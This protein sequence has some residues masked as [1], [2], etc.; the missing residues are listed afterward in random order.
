LHEGVFWQRLQLQSVGP[1]AMMTI[2][3]VGRLTGTEHRRPIRLLLAWFAILELLTLI[4]GHGLTVSAA[5]PDIKSFLWAG[6][7]LITYYESDVGA[8]FLFLILSAFIAYG[9]VVYV[10]F[11]HYRRERARNILAILV[12]NVA[13]FLG[14]S[15]DSLISFRVYSS[16]YVSE[17]TFFILTLSMA[18]VLMCKFVDLQSDVEALNVNLERT[19]AQ[20]T[21]AL[22]RSLEQ[23]RAMQDQLVEAS[24]RSGMADVAT[25]VLHN[26]GNALNS[27]NVSVSMLEDAVRQSHLTGFSK[28]IRLISEHRDDLPGFFAGDARAKR[29][30]EYL[31]ASTTRLEREHDTLAIELASLREHVDHVNVVISTQQS[32]TGGP[33][34]RIPTSLSAALDEALS[35]S[36]LR[37]GDPGVELERAYEPM[38]DVDIDRHK[39]LQVLSSLLDNAWDALAGV[40]TVPKRV[41]IQLRAL[42]AHRVAIEIEDSGRGIPPENLTLIFQHSVTAGTGRQGFGLHASACAAGEMG[43]TLIATSDG[44]GHGARFTLTLPLRVPGAL[45][46]LPALPAQ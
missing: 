4:P 10:L 28:V 37:H 42:D 33:A 36:L 44:L 16:I 31:A 21:A 8:I 34:I 1:I 32:H 18:Y 40:T 26:V 9:Y 14:V 23:Q 43:G 35:A 39:L 45:P 25:D 24:R 12:G 30:P 19:V 2:W 3:F 22:Q 46:A 27:V 38:P 5:T 29:L 11:W 6:Q 20:R 41:R 17:Y 7:P 15:N 13:Y